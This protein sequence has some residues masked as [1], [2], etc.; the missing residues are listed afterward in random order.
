MCNL[1]RC[2][3]VNITQAHTFTPRKHAEGKTADDFGIQMNYFGNGVEPHLYLIPTSLYKLHPAMDEAMSKLLIKDPLGLILMVEGKSS[4]WKDILNKRMSKTMP[5]DVFERI[6]WIKP[7]KLPD[8]LAFIKLGAVIMF[9][10]PIASGVTV[11]ESLSVGTPYVVF[12]VH[13]RRER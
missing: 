1:H 6:I 4:T 2:L 10:Y 11:M 13:L 7:M 5:M 9:N 3:T 8:Y 12:E